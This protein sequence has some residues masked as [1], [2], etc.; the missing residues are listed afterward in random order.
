MDT[1]GLTMIAIARF[2]L[3]GTG[4]SC[5]EPI[6]AALN[7]EAGILVR[8]AVSTLHL[9]GDLSSFLGRRCTRDVAAP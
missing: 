6:P 4:S 2:K 5:Q 1:R 7:C 8:P 9:S 3:S